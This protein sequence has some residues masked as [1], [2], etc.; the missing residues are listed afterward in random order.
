MRTATV[1]A[2]PGASSGQTSGVPP[3]SLK[4]PPL[5][6]HVVELTGTTLVELI[7]RAVSRTPERVALALRRGLVDERWTCR[8]LQ[9]RSLS[10]AAT[11]AAREIGAGDRV[12]TW[13]PNDP[14]MVAA[15]FAIWRL[16]A[17]C[18]PIDARTREG[19]GLL[20]SSTRVP[21]VPVHI[22]GAYELLPKGR[23]M[24]RRR[25]G[26]HVVV[27][28]GPALRSLAGRPPHEATQEIGDAIA[29]LAGSG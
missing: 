25:R 15:F 6:P 3:V 29:A 11:L 8:E 21:V 19:I 9:D 17:I 2:T 27:R 10:V 7:D 12:V 22:A 18:V 24:P 16:G 13:G 26:S 14:W 23:S 28:F 5:D 20:A 1:V 4:G